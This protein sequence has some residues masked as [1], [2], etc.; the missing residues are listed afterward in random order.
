MSK[1]SWKRMAGVPR[2]SK[3][4]AEIKEA[5]SNQPPGTVVVGPVEVVE[6][7]ITDSIVSAGQQN[8]DIITWVNGVPM[9]ARCERS[10]EI[11]EDGTVKRYQEMRAMPDVWM[12]PRCESWEK[13]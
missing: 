10:P 13:R 1:G 9:C 11:I 5:L 3:V 6:A 12:C 7:P 8:S 2:E 4:E